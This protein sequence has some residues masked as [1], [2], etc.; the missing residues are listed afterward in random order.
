MISE[1][2]VCLFMN[3]NVKMGNH[4]SAAKT[5][6]K[7]DHNFVFRHEEFGTRTTITDSCEK[8]YGDRVEYCNDLL[9]Q[10]QIK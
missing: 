8:C 3:V 2:V 6:N 9:K 7:C 10:V 5:E 4:P 1:G